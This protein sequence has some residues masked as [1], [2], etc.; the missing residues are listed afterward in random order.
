MYSKF[1]ERVVLTSTENSRVHLCTLFN[2]NKKVVQSHNKQH[3]KS[4]D[5]KKISYQHTFNNMKTTHKQQTTCIIV[6]TWP[7]HHDDKIND[8]RC[9]LGRKTKCTIRQ[10]TKKKSDTITTCIDYQMRNQERKSHESQ[11][12]ALP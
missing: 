5:R 4:I 8:I 1:T 10:L 11:P 2:G 12:T 7:C 6:T 3:T 9:Q